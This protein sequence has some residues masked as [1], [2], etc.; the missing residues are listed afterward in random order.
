MTEAELEALALA[1]GGKVTRFGGQNAEAAASCR[2]DGETQLVLPFARDISE[3]EFMAKVI[4]LAESQ[5]WH[6]YHTHDSRRSQT[7]FPDLVMCRALRLIFAELKSEV[8][9]PSKAQKQWLKDLSEAGGHLD[10]IEV[11]LWRPSDWPTI[12]EMLR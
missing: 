4:K 1:R 10:Q 7:G 2:L 9:K 12:V 5:G 3:K 8:G 6:C 11:H